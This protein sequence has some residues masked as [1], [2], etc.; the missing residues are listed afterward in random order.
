MWLRIPSI[1]IHAQTYHMQ[2]HYPLA[3]L[4]ICNRH[5][6]CF[7][8][9]Y[10]CLSVASNQ[11]KTKVL[12]KRWSNARILNNEYIAT[13]NDDEDGPWVSTVSVK[14]L[15]CLLLLQDVGDVQLEGTRRLQAATLNDRAFIKDSTVVCICVSP[16]KIS[17]N[18]V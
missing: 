5:N 13:L 12:N 6:I 14:P 3:N 4:V 2:L 18:A 7:F 17:F 10:G 9:M 16:E 11:S 8:I 1:N 15:P